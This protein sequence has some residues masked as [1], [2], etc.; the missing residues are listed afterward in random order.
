MTPLHR[1]ARRG[2]IEAIRALLAEGADIDAADARGRTP[3]V[4]AIRA[5]KPIAAGLLLGLGA[6]P[7]RRDRRGRDALAYA[8]D[9]SSY[10]DFLDALIARGADIDTFGP[11]LRQTAL[12]RAVAARDEARVRDLL[13][14]GASIRVPGAKSPLLALAFPNHVTVRVYPERGEDED[15]DPPPSPAKAIAQA[16]ASLEAFFGPNEPPAEPEPPPEPEPEP[17]D[18][19]ARL[20]IADVLVAAGADPNDAEDDGFTPLHWLAASLDAPLMHRLL[21]AGANPNARTRNDG[22]TPLLRVCRHWRPGDP[23]EADTQAC[24]DALM[25]AGASTKVRDREGRTAL[26]V[27]ADEGAD[28]GVRALLATGADPNAEDRA[29]RTPRDRPALSAFLPD[30]ATSVR[31]VALLRDAVAAGDLR[32][33]RRALETGVSPTDRRYFADG[34]DAPLIRAATMDDPSILDALLS[35]GA[36]PNYR[37]RYRLT[38]LLSAAEAGNSAAVERLRAAGAVD[39][40]AEP[41]LGVARFAETAARPEYVDWAARVTRLVGIEPTPLER[42]PGGLVWGFPQRPRTNLR[43]DWAADKADEAQMRAWVESPEWGGAARAAGF[44][45]VRTSGLGGRPFLMLLPTA[46]PFEV[47]AAIRPDGCNCEVYT[48]DIIAWLS[49][50]ARR[51]PFDLTGVAHD[52][53]ER[54]YRNPVRGVRRLAERMERFC[55]DIV[56][57]GVGTVRKLAR[58]LRATNRWYFWWD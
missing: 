22:E 13:A 24:F 50:M 23:R 8:L 21:R 33:V 35:A 49:R 15:A 53:L 47:V 32:A 52:W 36:D 48:A 12:A 55:P 17:G 28:A 27:A 37:H 10:A 41:S 1:A 58:H 14:R 44:H 34:P 11:S 57:Q 2:G 25:A 30:G 16:L 4:V 20:R 19:D 39:A 3:L 18:A 54:V 40:R 31:P 7:L 29:G 26:A 5:G 51:N 46:D 38:A 56:S 42:T 9:G 43:D 45:L 6:D